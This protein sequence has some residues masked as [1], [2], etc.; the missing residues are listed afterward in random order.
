[1]EHKDEVA[2]SGCCLLYDEL[3][4]EIVPLVHQSDL[5]I[6]ML[7]SGWI[8]P[9]LFHCISPLLLP[10]L[11]DY[12]FPTIEWKPQGVPERNPVL[13]PYPSSSLNTT[14]LQFLYLIYLQLLSH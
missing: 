3:Y 4:H 10:L 8:I 14:H 6:S 13:N 9:L 11:Y 7:V 5:Q 12:L 2:C 1:M